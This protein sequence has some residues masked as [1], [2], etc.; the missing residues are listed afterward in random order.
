[1]NRKMRT[2]M[3]NE[4]ARLDAIATDLHTGQGGLQLQEIAE[5]I[6]RTTTRIRF[7]LLT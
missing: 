1:M 7:I 5:L 4:L 6:T 3:N 2:E